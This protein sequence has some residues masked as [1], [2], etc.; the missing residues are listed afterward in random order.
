MKHDVFISFRAKDTRDNFVSHLCGCLRRKRIKTFL[1]DELPAEERYEESLKA[2][3]VSRISVIVFSENFADSKW[4]LDEVVAILKCKEKFGQIV[5]P[6]LYH[7]DPLDIENQTGSFGDAFA[8]RRDIAE[9]LQEWKESF[10]EAINLPGWSTAY[11]SDEEMLVNEIAR[12][13][14]NKLLR[15]SKT[16]VIIEWSLVITNLMLEIPSSVYDQISSAHK[17]LYALAAMSMSLLSWFK[18]PAPQDGNCP[19]M[20]RHHFAIAQ[21]YKDNDGARGNINIWDPF[22]KD[23][24]LSLASISVESGLKDTLQSISA[25]WIVNGYNKTGCYS[26]LCPGFVQVSSKFA[27]GARAEPVSIYDGQ[28]YHLEVS[29]L[30]D[31]YTGD[32]WFVLGDE[33]IGYWPRSLF[34]FEGLA[35]GA[36]RIF[37]GG[38]VFSSVENMISPIMGSGH[39]PQEGFK[40]AAFVNGLKVI[41][42]VS[43]EVTSPPTSGL[44]LFAD[45]P[46]CYNVQTISTVGEDWS[47]AIFY[48]G[49]GG[50][51]I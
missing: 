48:G 46:T 44:M 40:K 25:G 10:T 28:Q 38:E 11:L 42:H 16:K 22:V 39:F 43:K 51:T 34:H 5:I 19:G 7:V 30:K 31:Y 26:T 32:W 3:E 1:Y 23:D 21:Y 20:N 49:P 47:S 8:K 36:N 50:C 13:I 27:L 35:N 45:S 15:A 33:P 4:C 37:W 17:P 9:Q 2:I 24:Q 12:E 18:Y 29:L 6:V 14:E 41:D